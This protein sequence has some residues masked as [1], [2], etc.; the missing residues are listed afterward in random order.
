[1]RNKKFDVEEIRMKYKIVDKIAAFEI[2][3]TETQQFYEVVENVES[4]DVSELLQISTFSELSEK[5]HRQEASKNHFKTPEPPRNLN[6]LQETPLI[7]YNVLENPMKVTDSL[8]V[9]RLQ[10][11]I[12]LNPTIIVKNSVHNRIEL[13]R[14]DL[15]SHSTS[16]KTA[17]ERHMHQIHLKKSPNSGFTCKVCS[18]TFAKSAVLRAHEK[19]HLICRTSFD[20]PHCAKTLSSQTAVANHIKWMHAEKEFQCKVCEKKFA[21]VS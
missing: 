17:M 2:S 8:K 15:C 7:L 13:F 21:T 11:P 19:I 9:E 10:K 18:K 6:K 20:C 5:T 4:E 1:M 12:L 3:P 14:C 16:T